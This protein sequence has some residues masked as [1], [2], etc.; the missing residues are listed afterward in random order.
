MKIII[1]ADT[2]NPITELSD[3]EDMGNEIS[4]QNPDITLHLGDI[5]ESRIGLHYFEDVLK[6]LPLDAVLLGNHDLWKSREGHDSS[7][8]WESVLPKIIQE[9]GIHYLEHENLVR[10]R[11]A[12]VGSYLHYNYS[13]ADTEGLAVAKIHAEIRQVFPDWTVNDYYRVMKKK[14]NNDGSFL[15][16]LPGKDD[17]AFAALIGAEFMKRLAQAENDSSVHSIVIVTHVSCMPS[18]ITRKPYDLGWSLGTPYFGNLSYVVPIL[19]SKKVKAIIGAHSHQE[20]K[21][22]EK[23]DDGREVP[24]YNL[25]SDYQNPKFLTLEIEI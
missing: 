17:K 2:H 19:A 1:T 25:G 23:F 24:T 22:S 10:D 5:G 15:T 6:V 21:S 18:L 11:V 9:A 20:I 14:V 16:N 12:I 13:A 7:E 4:A 3:I 8:L